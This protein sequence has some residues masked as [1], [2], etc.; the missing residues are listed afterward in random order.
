[1]LKA[2]KRH[3]ISCRCDRYDRARTKCTC[4]YHAIGVRAAFAQVKRS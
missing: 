1:M 2:E 3:R 4:S